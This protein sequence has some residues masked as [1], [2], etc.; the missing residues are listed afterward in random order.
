V[1]NVIP[2]EARDLTLEGFRRARSEAWS[3]SLCEI[4]HFVQDDRFIGG[5]MHSAVLKWN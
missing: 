4:L 5:V 1:T 2:S 3:I